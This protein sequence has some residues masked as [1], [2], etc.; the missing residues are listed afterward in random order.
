MKYL[1]DTY[2]MC[3]LS[4]QETRQKKKD[5][6]MKEETPDGLDLHDTGRERNKREE[7]ENNKQMPLLLQMLFFIENIKSGTST[8][9]FGQLFLSCGNWFSFLFT[10]P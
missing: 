1:Q 5:K 8:K 7:K 4:P 9:S 6:K 10:H 3:Q 2:V